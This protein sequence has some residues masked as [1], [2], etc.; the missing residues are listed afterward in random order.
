MDIEGMLQQLREERTALEEAIVTLE[1]LA[2]GRG[3]RRGRPPKWLASM[4]P[5][6]AKKRGR[7]PKRAVKQ[8]ALE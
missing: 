8:A 4:Q 5:T 3:K 2:A 6:V 7:P 1:R